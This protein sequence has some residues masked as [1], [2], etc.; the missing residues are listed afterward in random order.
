MKGTKFVLGVL[1]LVIGVISS[2]PAQLLF[3]NLTLSSNS[4]LVSGVA[5]NN[6]NAVAYDGTSNF[7]AVG[8][9]QVF[10]CGDFNTNQTWFAGPNWTAGHVLSATNGLNLD[11][12]TIG[13]N[14]FVATG[15]KNTIFSVTNVFAQ[16]GGWSSNGTIFNNT[17]I[18][19]G[20]AYNAGVFAAIGEAPLISWTNA[21]QPKTA[22]WPA[23]T[24]GGQDFIESFRGVTAYGNNNGFAACGFYSDLLTSTNGSYWVPVSGQSQEPPLYGIASD[25]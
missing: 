2:A 12:V 24:L 3:T 18:A 8:A 14:L 21:I 1:A 13:N 11:A 19:P 5:N 7:L 23:G 20:I 17:V 22:S 25:G 10:V 15:D 4:N 6:L 9:N 16:I